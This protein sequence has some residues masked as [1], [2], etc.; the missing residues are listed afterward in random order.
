MIDIRTSY[1]VRTS[2]PIHQHNPC[3]YA[4]DAGVVIQQALPLAI[5][6]LDIDAELI[7][8]NAFSNTASSRDS[9]FHEV[10]S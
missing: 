10:R 8:L 3:A 5:E 6:I 9:S 7:K 2:V 4:I 1:F